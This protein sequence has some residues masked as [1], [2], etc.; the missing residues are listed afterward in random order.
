MTENGRVKKLCR[1]SGNDGKWACD[2]GEWS[3]EIFLGMNGDDGE[4]ACKKCVE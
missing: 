4:W 3:C 2:D 1:T